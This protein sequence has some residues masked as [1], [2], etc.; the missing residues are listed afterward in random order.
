MRLRKNPYKALERRLGYRFRRRDL[1]EAALT[2]PSFR[3]ESG[4][5][6]MDNQRLEFLGDAVLGMAAAAHLYTE[7]C[8]IGEGMLTT[9][10]SQITRG[11]ALAGLARELGVGEFLRMGRG[12]TGSGGRDRQSNLEDAL[13]A[14]IGAIYLDGGFKAARKVFNRVFVPAIDELSDDAWAGN[15]KGKLQEFSQ[16]RWK[17]SPVYDV[18]KQDGPPHETTFTVSVRLLDDRTGRGRGRS[19]QEAERRAAR[20]LLEALGSEALDSDA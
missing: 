18:L 4:V 7:K 12:E 19:K 3:V 15:P 6:V 8:E 1:L 10:R 2:H 9:L 14:V 11:R 17:E 5:E 20:A 13:E 16:R